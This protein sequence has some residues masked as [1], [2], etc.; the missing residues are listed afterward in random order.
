M[1]GFARPE[2]LADTAW[3]AGRLDDPGLRIVDCDEPDGYRRAHIPGAV[4]LSVHHYLKETEDDPHIMRPEKF[5]ALMSRLGIDAATEVITYDTYGGLYAARL[6]WALGY[7]GHDRCRVLDGGW[8]EWFREGR[9]AVR[10]PRIPEPKTF[11]ARPRPEWI[12]LADDLAAGLGR[13]DRRILDV[14]SEAE[15]TGKN[16]RGTKR[17]GRIPGARH[18]EW[19]RAV[20]DDER[21][22]FR[23]PEAVRA[24][25][26]ALG[27]TPDHEIVTYCQRG[28]RAAHGFFTLRLLGFDR[29]RNYDASWY[30]WG[31]RLELP[32]E[33]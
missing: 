24:E 2:L 28:I 31:N 13:P 17:G 7:Y 10:T 8:N 3:L 18:Y 30:E 16:K 1:P 19:L 15:H 12:A 14:R 33:A 6:W 11:T 32:V 25:L 27:L 20:T 22:A 26:A 29:V 9:A 23:D 21:M 5:S 4:A